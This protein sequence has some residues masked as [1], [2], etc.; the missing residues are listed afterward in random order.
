MSKIHPVIATLALL[1][2]A[3]L[4]PTPADAAGDGMQE[5]I[6][7]VMARYPGGVQTGSGE[8]SWENGEVILTLPGGTAKAVGSCA[9]GSFCAYTG[10]NLSGA[11]I[12]FT[13]CA[14][15]NSVAPLGSAV[16]SFANGRPSGTVYAYN[17]A[18]AVASTSAGS[19]QNTTATITRL[20]C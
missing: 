11:R 17:G 7:A 5:R 6:D 2:L 18:T 15:S 1:G 14:G 12:S 19:F 3:I 20:G 10:S 16:R 13:N 4:T 8:I 9:S